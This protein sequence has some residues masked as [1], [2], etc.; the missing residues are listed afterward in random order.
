MVPT[1]K[2]GASVPALLDDLGGPSVQ[3]FWNDV[4]SHRMG[5]TRW[6][7]G[8]P[9]QPLAFTNECGQCHRDSLPN[10]PMP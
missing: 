9:E 5:I 10:T 4:A 6:E 2:S 3:Y 1:A 7:G 8:Q